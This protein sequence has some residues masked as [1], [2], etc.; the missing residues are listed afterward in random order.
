M[1]LYDDSILFGIKGAINVLDELWPG[2]PAFVSGSGAFKLGTDSVMLA[3][4]AK[5][6]RAELACDI[7]CGAGIIG[8]LLAHKNISLSVDCVDIQENACALA[9]ENVRI[10]GLEDRLRI[11]CGD[12][13]LHRGLLKAGAYDLVLSNPP[14]YALGRGK[15]PSDT[16]MLLAR[17]EEACSIEDVCEAARY[18]TRWGGSFALVHKPERLA[19]VIASLV[20]NG[21][22]PKRLRFV[23]NRPES[24]PS[25]FM[26]EARRGGKPSLKIE[27]PLILTDTDGGESDEILRIYNKSKE[28]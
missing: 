20:K 5:D 14:Y 23:H 12:I 4:F 15:M 13:R 6:I 1:P 3:D 21:L 17:S 26:I 11:I 19:E 18:L 27:P 25:L 7:G 28:R 9:I 16:G 8:I 10:N 22:E 24:A 2:G